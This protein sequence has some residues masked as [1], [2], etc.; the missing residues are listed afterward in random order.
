MRNVSQRII[1]VHTYI[2]EK[3]QTHQTYLGDENITL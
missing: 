1:D 3:C 2:N